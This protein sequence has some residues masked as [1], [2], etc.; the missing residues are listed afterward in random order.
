MRENMS[1]CAGAVQEAGSSIRSATRGGEH[2][3]C[4]GHTPVAGR[5][6][7]CETQSITTKDRPSLECVQAA[8]MC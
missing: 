8:T 1:F 6:W 5:P 2:E 3:H 7:P 4:R